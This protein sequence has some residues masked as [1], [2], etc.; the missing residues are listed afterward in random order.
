MVFHSKWGHW[1]MRQTNPTLTLDF[2]V[3]ISGG[4][5]MRRKRERFV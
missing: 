2:D 3:G 4:E 1:L 5:A